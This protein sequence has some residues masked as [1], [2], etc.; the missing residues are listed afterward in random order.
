MAESPDDIKVLN[1][2]KIHLESH[3]IESIRW[4]T[5]VSKICLSELDDNAHRKRP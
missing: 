5:E 1:D 2:G 4:H 3:T